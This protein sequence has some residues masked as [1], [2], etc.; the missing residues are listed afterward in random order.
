MQELL[1]QFSV[2]SKIE[3]LPTN[4]CGAALY[5]THCPHKTKRFLL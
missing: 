3:Q 1:Q 2:N 5:D 4:S